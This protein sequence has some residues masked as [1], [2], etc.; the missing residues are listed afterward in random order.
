MLV[1]ANSLRALIWGKPSQSASPRNKEFYRSNTVLKELS[2]LERAWAQREGVAA[3]V[4]YPLIVEDRLIGVMAVFARKQLSEAAITT[5][6]AIAGSLS[7]GI[8]GKTAEMVKRESEGRLRQLAENI[9]E[10]FWMTDLA[11][12]EVLYV[13]PAYEAVWG[14]TC[15][16]L[17]ED[18][19][20]FFDAIHSDDRPRVLAAI[21]PKSDVPYEIEY[22]IVRPDHSVRWIR[23]RAFPVRDATG[24]M[25]RIAGVAEDVTEKRQL[26]AQLFQAQ[27]MQAIGRLAGGVAH[28]F[29]NLLSVIFGHSALLSTSSPSPERLRDSVTEINQAAERAAAL[30]R[31]LL[32]FGRRQVVEPKILDLGAVLT[33]SRNFCAG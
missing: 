6:A 18:H 10:V 29:N 4:G 21:Y 16:S 31:Q 27:K 28:D 19:Q 20:S 11:N 25:I 22:R 5:L 23:D 9:N 3:F 13:S 26:E 33:E 14:R 7:L 2:S 32:A 30:T 24:R 12:K 17:L 15:E 8:Q 1:R